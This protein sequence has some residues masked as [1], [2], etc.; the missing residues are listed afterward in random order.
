MRR[1]SGRRLVMLLAILLVA[2]SLS[3][4]ANGASECDCCGPMMTAPAAPA[5]PCCVGTAD[6]RMAA[7]TPLSSA[8]N[9]T[10]LVKVMVIAGGELPLEPPRRGYPPGQLRR[11]Y[12]FIPVLRI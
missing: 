8:S 3:T 12:L 6:R 1:S 4:R 7:S 11:I 2:T 10:L 5:P 9:P